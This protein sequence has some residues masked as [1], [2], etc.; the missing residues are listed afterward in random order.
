VGVD[1]RAPRRFIAVLAG[2]LAQ[3][4]A[5]LAPFVALLVE[6]LRDRAPSRP[7]GQRLLLLARS[8]SLLVLEDA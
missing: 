5:R 7:R 1:G 8:R 2:E 4:R 6:E 3:L